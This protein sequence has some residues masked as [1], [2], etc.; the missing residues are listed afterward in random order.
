VSDWQAPPGAAGSAGRNAIP[1]R[2]P[3]G[4]RPTAG[5]LSDGALVSSPRC[6]RVAARAAPWPGSRPRWLAPRPRRA[7]PDRW[8]SGAVRARCFLPSTICSPSAPTKRASSRNRSGTSENSSSAIRYGAAFSD[9]AAAS[10]RP[11]L[12][13]RALV[14][15][16]EPRPAVKRIELLRRFTHRNC[17][18]RGLESFHTSTVPRHPATTQQRQRPINQRGAV[19]AIMARSCSSVIR[20]AAGRPASRSDSIARITDLQ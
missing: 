2:R 9:A 8:R 11:A 14:G 13:H 10:R 4:P 1:D 15:G 5:Q 19:G 6:S 16:V 17:R 12:R 7:S 18:W 3:G 20:R